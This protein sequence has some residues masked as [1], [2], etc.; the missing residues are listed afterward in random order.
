[1]KKY[2]VFTDNAVNTYLL[3]LLT[4]EPDDSLALAALLGAHKNKELE[5]VGIVGTSGNT[6]TEKSF[7]NCRKQVKLSGQD[8]PVFKGGFNENEISEEL[9]EIIR[10][11]SDISLIVLGPLTDL[12]YLLKNFPWTKQH[13]TDWL[14]SNTKM[15]NRGAFKMLL[16]L[17]QVKDSASAKNVFNELPIKHELDETIFEVTLNDEFIENL[18][19]IES[20]MLRFISKSLF[21]WN[22]EYKSRPTSKSNNRHGNMCPWDLVW[23]STIL[24]PQLFHKIVVGNKT[25]YGIKN[26]PALLDRFIERFRMLEN[27]S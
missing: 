17:N 13:F 7:H 16:S 15:L 27:Q 2:L 21:D 12:A 11:T 20:P 6:S 1:M 10:T 9:L 14:Y 8:V 18:M 3:G 25:I 5:V 19:K 4:S 24:D 22:K 26:V 23:V